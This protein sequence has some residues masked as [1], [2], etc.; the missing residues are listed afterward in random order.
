MAIRYVNKM[1]KGK[2]IKLIIKSK[3][4]QIYFKMCFNS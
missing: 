3:R 2:S 4:L 1:D